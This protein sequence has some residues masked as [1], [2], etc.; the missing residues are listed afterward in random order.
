[1]TAFFINQPVFRLLSDFC[2]DYAPTIV[3]YQI[4]PE[5]IVIVFLRFFNI[6]HY[7]KCIF[8]LHWF[9]PD[10]VNIIYDVYISLLFCR[11][12]LLL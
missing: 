12:C 5:Q 11:G 2:L 1:M 9:S 3:R 6:L 10:N 4:K 7:N 8:W